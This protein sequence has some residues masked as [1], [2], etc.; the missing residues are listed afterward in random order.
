MTQP[1]DK[2]TDVYPDKIYRRFKPISSIVWALLIC[3]A[4]CFSVKAALAFVGGENTKLHELPKREYCGTFYIE[5]TPEFYFGTETRFDEWKTEAQTL[6]GSVGYKAS[7]FAMN[8]MFAGSMFSLVIFFRNAV[9]RRLFCGRSSKFVILSGILLCASKVLQAILEYEVFLNQKPYYAGLMKDCEYYFRAY[10]VFAL[11]ALMIM[12][13]L[14]LKK[15]E[16]MLRGENKGSAAL[17]IYAVLFAVWSF[18][19][20]MYRLMIRIYELINALAEWEIDARLPF[21]DTLI[22]LPRSYAKNIDTYT[23]MIM[24]RFLKDM[25]VFIAAG[26]AVIMLMLVM[27]SAARGKINSE[28]NR[29]LLLLSVISLVT[30]SLL[31]NIMGLHEV[32]MLNEGFSGFYGN[33]GYAVGLCSL[34]EPALYAIVIFGIYA[35]IG[36]ITACD[37]DP[38]AK[39][40]R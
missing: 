30:A 1:T 25:P 3:I 26:V 37:T 39:K 14:I 27:F 7:E 12:L 23:D 33:T 34:C 36:L 8:A 19:S 35:F 17:R 13:G 31:F 40:E 2:T 5:A 18:G 4:V 29:T 38:N 21:N 11:P 9:K 20:I 22:P 16:R 28:N 6:Y 24:F 10:S 32:S 15:H